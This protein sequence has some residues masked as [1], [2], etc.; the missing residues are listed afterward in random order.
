MLVLASIF[1][2]PWIVLAR[3]L[4]VGAAL[5]WFWR[6]Y[7]ELRQPGTVPAAQWL[8]AVL[9]G[10][11]TFVIWTWLDHR[12]AAVSRGPGF[13]PRLPE[14]GIDWRLALP[15]LAAFALVV[16]LMEELFWRSFLLRWLERHDFLAVSPGRVGAR[17]FLITTALFALEHNQW[18]A[19]AVAGMVYNGVYMRSGNLWIPIAAH[20]VTNTSLGVWILWTGNW[21]FW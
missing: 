7:S 21:H 17:A 4:I 5:I 11:A 2:A 16:P 13:D 10:I 1:A 20:A 14:G 9:A 3:G 6:D 18:L 19:G 8:L 15:R 12:W